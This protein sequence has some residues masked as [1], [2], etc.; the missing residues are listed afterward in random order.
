M[1]SDLTPKVTGVAEV[2][3]LTP[4]GSVQQLVKVTFTVGAHGPFTA[5]LPRDGFTAAAVRTEMEKVA[6]PLRELAV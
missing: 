6:A 2:V 1:Q 4:Q 5:T 3:Q